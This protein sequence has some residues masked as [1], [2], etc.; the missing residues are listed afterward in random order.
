MF[1]YMKKNITILR[2]AM[3]TI[4]LQSKRFYDSQ[5]IIS[6]QKKTAG[7]FFCQ[8]TFNNRKKDMYER[9][10]TAYFRIKKM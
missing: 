7:R 10:C 4:A 5:S 3:S 1:A 8:Q 9:H 6:Q 2:V